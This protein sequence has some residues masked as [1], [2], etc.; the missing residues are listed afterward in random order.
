MRSTLCRLSSVYA[1]K[2]ARGII[3]GDRWA[4]SRG[5]TLVESSNIK[6]SL[7][8]DALLDR[9]MTMRDKSKQR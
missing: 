1:D 6:H 2:I 4:L 3:D 8:A 9:I 7:E 5:I